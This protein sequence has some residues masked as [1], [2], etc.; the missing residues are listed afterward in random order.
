ML[1]RA[2]I[3]DAWLHAMR[4]LVPASRRANDF[5]KFGVSE[6]HR[7][8]AV[9]FTAFAK[10]QTLEVRLH[11][12]TTDYTKVLAWIRLCELLAAMRT[13]PKAA[14][15]IATLEQLPLASHDLAYWR[16]RHRELNP[17]MYAANITSE[18]EG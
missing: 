6:G 14:G 10:Y 1:K 3:M 13:K 7:Y 4:E 16:A 18:Q 15:C 17:T 12:G 5:C 11:S 9:N 2:K 8:H